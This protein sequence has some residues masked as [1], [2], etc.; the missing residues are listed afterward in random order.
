MQLKAWYQ[1]IL[2]HVP[3]TMEFVEPVEHLEL[4]VLMN[5]FLYPCKY[6]TTVVGGLSITKP[7]DKPKN[8]VDDWNELVIRSCLKKLG[9]RSEEEIFTNNDRT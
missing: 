6:Y 2:G 5:C 4:L 8:L 1:R 7:L 9:K 3:E